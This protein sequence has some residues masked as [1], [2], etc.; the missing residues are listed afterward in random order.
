MT[1]SYDKIADV[2]YITFEQVS[3]ESYLYVENDSGDILRVDKDSQKVV[4]V[5]LPF[6]L[7]R[8][9]KGKITIP[10]VGLVPFNDQALEL[11]SE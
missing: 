4:G 1:L 7:A 5:T 10:E 8:A 3:G 11:I 2:L 6:F 9:K